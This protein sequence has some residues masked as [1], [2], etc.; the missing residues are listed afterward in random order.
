MDLPGLQ[1]GV[2]AGGEHVDVGLGGGVLGEQ[3]A[4]KHRGEG[5]DVDDVTSLQAD[6]CLGGWMD[7]WMLH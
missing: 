5:G 3:G 2:E 1:L 4:G 6:G 7:G